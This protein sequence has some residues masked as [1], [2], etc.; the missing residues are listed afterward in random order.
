[1]T[2]FKEGEE[3]LVK[4]V[5]S[6]GKINSDGEVRFDA[7][8]F[9]DD[10]VKWHYCLPS[11][12]VKRSA[13]PEFEY[14]EEIEVRNYEDVEWDKRIYINIGKKGEFACVFSEDNFDFRNG[15]KFE[16]ARWKYARKLQKEEPNREAMDEK[17]IPLGTTRLDLLELRVKRLEEKGGVGDNTSYTWQIW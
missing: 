6:S 13:L 4:G 12:I 8:R 16:I 14:G 3:V 1:M 10:K 5:I 7:K 11:E 2:E 17:R 9:N 15:E